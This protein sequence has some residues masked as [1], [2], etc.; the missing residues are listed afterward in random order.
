MKQYYEVHITFTA[1]TKAFAKYLQERHAQSWTFSAIDADIILGEG[2]K[3]Y[4]TKHYNKRKGELAIM[5]ELNDVA[6]AMSQMSN[7]I[8]KKIELVVYD[9]RL[10]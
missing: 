6:N 1:S 7:I 9:E 10:K 3:F 2:V 8:R 4:L 5:K